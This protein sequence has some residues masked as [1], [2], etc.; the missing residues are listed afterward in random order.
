MSLCLLKVFVRFHCLRCWEDFCCR[1]SLHCSQLQTFR[2]LEE[3][4]S[5]NRN[6][7]MYVTRN[8]HSAQPLSCHLWCEW[9]HLH[10]THVYTVCY[11]TVLPWCLGLLHR[12]FFRTNRSLSFC[13]CAG[14]CVEMTSLSHRK[15]KNSCR[16]PC[17]QQ[18]A[19]RGRVFVPALAPCI[20]TLIG[21]PR[22]SVGQISSPFTCQW[23]DSGALGAH[24]GFKSVSC[25]AQCSQSFLLVSDGDGAPSSSGCELYWEASSC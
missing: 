7:C 21:I 9:Q 22:T 19:F 8:K 16:A 14:N 24:H 3:R 25:L 1:I 11:S 10:L 23:I 5:L 12:C 15:R 20:W 6:E 2:R 17:E 13:P 4:F 18:M